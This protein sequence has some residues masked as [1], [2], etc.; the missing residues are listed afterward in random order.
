MGGGGYFEGEKEREASY[1]FCKKGD[2]WVLKDG[3]EFNN[4][5][6]W[7]WGP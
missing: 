4:S 5:L 7:Q 3:E 6:D 1:K 2:Y